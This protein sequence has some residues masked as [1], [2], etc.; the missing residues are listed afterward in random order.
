MAR[1]AGATRSPCITVKKLPKLNCKSYSQHLISHKLLTIFQRDENMRLNACDVSQVSEISEVVA[2]QLAEDV[3]CFSAVEASE[4][5]DGCNAIYI[6]AVT[7]KDILTL[8]LIRIWRAIDELKFQKFKKSLPANTLEDGGRSCHASLFLWFDYTSSHFSLLCGA[9]VFC[10][11][12][13]QDGSLSI[14][15]SFPLEIPNYDDVIAVQQ[16]ESFLFLLHS[17]GDI[18]IFNS[19]YLYQA[20]T[21]SFRHFIEVLFQEM[22]LVDLFKTSKAS[23]FTVSTDMKTIILTFSGSK[24]SIFKI[25]LNEYFAIFPNHLTKEKRGSDIL[26]NII[27]QDNC[28][29]KQTWQG[30]MKRTQ[31]SVIQQLAIKPCKYGVTCKCAQNWFDESFKP[32]SSLSSPKRNTSPQMTKKKIAG[33]LAKKERKTFLVEYVDAFQHSTALKTPKQC[34]DLSMTGLWITESSVVIWYKGQNGGNHGGIC[35]GSIEEQDLEFYSFTAP[36]FLAPPVEPVQPIAMVSRNKLQLLAAGV[37]Q[38]ILVNKLMMYKNA[39]LAETV[40]HLNQWDHCSIPIHALEVGLRHRQLDTVAFFL[41][42]R[43]T[44]F[45]LK[46]DSNIKPDMS[47]ANQ[48]WTALNLLSSTIKE[49]M[50]DSQSQHYSWQLLNLTLS[51]LHKLIQNTTETKA[52]VLEKE[53]NGTI[54]GVWGRADDLLEIID[55]LMQ[56]ITELRKYLKGYPTKVS[57]DEVDS[58]MRS[59]KISPWLGHH[60]QAGSSF[61]NWRT[62]SKQDVIKDAILSQNIPLAQAY[63]RELQGESTSTLS[64]KDEIVNVGQTIAYNA[65][66]ESNIETAQTM[67]RNMGFDVPS[68]LKKICFFSANSSLRDF[69]VQ[70]LRGKG[71]ISTQESNVCLFISSLERLY[72]CQSFEKA[73]NLAEE[74]LMSL[75]KDDAL[76]LPSLQNTKCERFLADNLRTGEIVL[77]SETPNC[78]NFNYAHVLFDWIKYWN[79]TTKDRIL[80]ERSIHSKGRDLSTMWSIAS[81]SA[82]Q[83]L[84]A[85]EDW[86]TL[87]SWI[88]YTFS[89][90]TVTISGSLPQIAPILQNL[91]LERDFVNR[92]D[93]CTTYF[94]ERVLGEMA[95]LGIFLSEEISSFNQLLCRLVRSGQLLVSPHIL[96]RVPEGQMF[97]N[98]FNQ[99]FINYCIHQHL[100]SVL[101]IFIEFYSLCLS[102]NEVLNM[103]LPMSDVPWLEILLNFRWIGKQ[104]TDPALVFQAS[105]ANSRLLQAVAQ[106]SVTSL[107]QDGNVVV[108]LA[109]LLYA[110]GNITEA[111]NPSTSAEKLWKV[112]HIMLEQC[113]KPYPKLQRAIFP[114]GEED[115]IPPQDITVYQLLKGNIPVHCAKTFAWQTSNNVAESTDIMH[116][117]MPHF[118]HAD[119]V[120]MFAY[121]ES[122]SFTHYLRQGRPSFAFSAFII[123]LMQENGSAYKYK[124]CQAYMKSYCTAVRNISKPS[125]TAACVAF[126]EMLGKSS[127]SVRVDVHSAGV[128]LEFHKSKLG[129]LSS[130]TP[131][132]TEKRIQDELKNKEEQ[133]VMLLM[134]CLKGSQ[135]SA[136][137]VLEMLERAISAKVN[138]QFQDCTSWEASEVW[139]LAVLFCQRHNLPYS[140]VYLKQCAEKNQWLQFTCFAQIHQYS[141]TQILE[142][143]KNFTIS[144]LRDHLSS[145]FENMKFGPASSKPE[146]MAANHEQLMATKNIRA[147]FYAKFGVLSKTDDQHTKT[148]EF[149]VSDNLSDEEVTSEDQFVDDTDVDNDDA[150]TVPKDLDEK[151]IPED[152]FGIIFHCDAQP[153]P[154]NALLSHA[155]ASSQPILAVMA[156][157]YQNSSPVD[158][159]CTWLYTIINERGRSKFKSSLASAASF[160]WHSWTLHELFRLIYAAIESGAI[161]LVHKGFFIF[162]KNC[163]LNLFLRFCCEFLLHFDVTAAKDHLDSFQSAIQKC[164]RYENIQLVQLETTHKPKIGN[165]KWYQQS[166][167]QIAIFMLSTCSSHWELSSLLQLLSE[168]NFSLIVSSSDPDYSL[169]YQLN[170]ILKDTSQEHTYFSKLICCEK[171]SFQSECT[172]ILE[173]LQ[174]SNQFNKAKMFARLTRLP[175]DNLIFSQVE[176]ELVKSRPPPQVVGDDAATDELSFWQKCNDL[177]K[178]NRVK[179]KAAV[180]F[181]QNWVNRENT[182]VV[183]SSTEKAFILHL[184]YEWMKKVSQGSAVSQ[185]EREMWTWRLKVEAEKLA[186][187]NQ[188]LH[189]SHNQEEGDVWEC[190]SQ[191]PQELLFEE[192]RSKSNDEDL[193]CSEEQ[194]SALNSILSKLLQ[195]GCVNQAH[196]LSTQFQHYCQDLEIILSCIL[197]AKGTLQTFQL[198]SDLKRLIGAADQRQHRRTSEWQKPGKQTTFGGSNTP[199]VMRRSVS[200]VSVPTNFMDQN[201]EQEVED[202]VLKT[203]K[204]LSSFCKDGS[205]CCEQIVT[206]YQISK[207]L[208]KTYEEVVNM[209]PLNTLKM[210]LDSHNQH[211]IELAKK[212]VETN[213]LP[214]NEVASFLT[215]LVLSS[216]QKFSARRKEGVV[217]RLANPTTPI[218]SWADRNEFANLL[219]LCQNPAVLGNKLMEEV[220]SLIRSHKDPT[221]QGHLSGGLTLVLSLEVELLIRAHDCFSICCHMEGISNVLRSTREIFNTLADF[222]EYPLMVRLLLGVARYSEMT[223]VF[224]EL[225]SKQQIEL[226]LKKGSKDNSLKVS[227]LDYLKRCEPSDPETYNVV[228]VKFGMVREIA[229]LLEKEGVKKLN[230]VSNRKMDTNLEVQNS[231]EEILQDFKNAAQNYAKADCL[232]HAERCVQ[233]ARLVAL[234]LHLLSHGIRVISLM[235][236]ELVSFLTK[237]NNFHQA[238]IVHEAYGKQ[239]DWS[240]SIYYQVVEKGDFV[241]FEDYR[242]ALILTDSLFRDVAQLYGKEKSRGGT[243]TNNMKQLV[244]LCPD[245]VAKYRIAAEFGFQEITSLLLQDE[246]AAYLKDVTMLM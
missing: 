130:K 212:F 128:I 20:A 104:A 113:L 183:L 229:T 23:S 122:F 71:H 45:R 82:W 230:F 89:S 156:S 221:K 179:P 207:V 175:I 148:Q 169:L 64:R 209:A 144:A 217:S 99:W 36:T 9:K 208:K 39:S 53:G 47:E 78:E 51:H 237:H 28:E 111:L 40:S 8:E 188:E 157:C 218:S 101:Y 121:I 81:E 170:L 192:R 116:G 236:N 35:T 197:L 98:S 243:V 176:K 114:Q 244:M 83:F 108:A 18:S 32:T 26:T 103:Q 202:E 184:A 162:D 118:S 60:S 163:P 143:L 126:A 119:L 43:E 150:V 13:L 70:E 154:F 133:L 33:F 142:L 4:V 161:N 11:L 242:S 77:S 61:L 58:T 21:I 25:H 189:L 231:L 201:L 100:P 185:L 198:D 76:K 181:F 90:S 30:F 112:D 216:L 234:Q 171:E 79:K 177:F 67:F 14:S 164:K 165:L 54:E 203:M 134:A 138:Q 233:Q 10:M 155:I 129:H 215:E 7:G 178:S 95:R 19:R 38:D 146:Q 206:C 62:F 52:T 92:M 127:T 186:V 241:Y 141:R 153:Q 149:S 158:C 220:I 2:F 124:I 49:N 75:W 24:Y 224:D 131:R 239:F 166:A 226:L 44:E 27:G 191:G 37:N 12:V 151:D 214:D 196:H 211:R 225:R 68:E 120:K 132:N 222:K 172:F 187:V 50:R 6:L 193:N 69:L 106:P 213:I 145:A 210:L 137:Y 159:L 115:G 91:I 66:V 31:L 110:P 140:T 107:L 136:I 109:T 15:D 22:S 205:N 246:N 63:L 42:G 117:E 123:N 232:R 94:K 228:A 235:D 46:P 5:T 88:E 223:Y 125:V 56:F 97:V 74:G 174:D 147:K 227:L 219:K 3:Q 85:H 240:I 167:N 41:K 96:T 1:E 168:V 180:S 59:D 190:K 48:L 200:V 93:Y 84:L 194:L 86:I 204:S 135:S 80:L 102:E 238:Y 87:K 173:R 17:T 160:Q 16:E 34:R 29:A 73:K 195:R 182:D 55:K 65:L 57:Q 139:S 199:P 105:L 72:T 245:I 152:F